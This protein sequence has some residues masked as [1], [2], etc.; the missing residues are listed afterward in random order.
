MSRSLRQALIYSTAWPTSTR[1]AAMANVPHTRDTKQCGCDSAKSAVL[2]PS[3]KTPSIH[4]YPA[5]QLIC[6]NTTARNVYPA[7]AKGLRPIGAAG[8][9][10]CLVSRFQQTPR[11]GE[12][13][14]GEI[15]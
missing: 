13:L 7:A 14:G 12:S 6:E 4:I 8:Q 15:E 5:C 2:A 3:A 9:A 10:Q 11:G 1:H